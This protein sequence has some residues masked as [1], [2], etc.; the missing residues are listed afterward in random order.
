VKQHLTLIAAV[1]ENGVIGRDGALPWRLPDDLKRFRRLTLGN[2]V[3]MGRKTFD[4]LGKPLDGRSNWVLSRDPAFASP[5]VRVFRELAE[6]LAAEPQGELL[7]IGGGELYR[8]ALP[9]AQRL[10][11]TLVHAAPPGD[12]WF[13]AYDPAQWHEAARTDHVA[14]ERHSCAYSFVT[15][16]KK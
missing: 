7:V 4:S 1:A 15:L 13:P 5:Q 10:E 8:Q 2:T 16:V 11:L 12:A 14:D 9:W 3:L 6:A